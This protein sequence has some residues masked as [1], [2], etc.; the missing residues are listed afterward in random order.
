LAAAL[1]AGQAAGEDILW[2][3]DG[4]GVKGTLEEMTFEVGGI[5]RACER[6]EI[7]SVALAAEGKDAAVLDGDLK[8]E[9]RMVSIRFRTADGVAMVSRKQV[10]AIEVD[11]DWTPEARAKQAEEE[12]EDAGEDAELTEEEKAAKG[13]LS[14]NAAL[15]KACLAKARELEKQEKR[16]V[17]SKYKKDVQ[18]TQRE[19]RA[20]ENRIAEKERRRREEEWR[21]RNNDDYRRRSYSDG[22]QGDRRALQEAVRKLEN[23]G[24]KIREE[25]KELSAKAD[26]R[27]ERI[28]AVYAGHKRS[29]TA[30]NELNQEQMTENY[31]A[32]LEHK[33][34]TAKKGG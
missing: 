12:A 6:I 16:G 7:A 5:Q 4:R 23:I 2:Y 8:V 34:K 29:I 18:N 20:I 9:G 30:G 14:I 15:A 19:I 32:A 26:A 22:I 17:N 27:E 33:V 21:S 11:P 31:K 3:A 28:K 25:K 13:A 24:K 1:F 10:K